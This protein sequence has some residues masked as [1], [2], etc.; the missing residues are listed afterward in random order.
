[1]PSVLPKRHRPGIGDK[2]EARP[3]AE[4]RAAFA[5]VAE[6]IAAADSAIRDAERK[7]RELDRE[8]AR[9]EADRRGKAAEPRLEVR[10]DLA[11]A[12]ATRA[13]LRV[14]Y[15]VRQARWAPLYDARLDT[16]AQ[17]PQARA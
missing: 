16:G 3:I 10:I 1:M 14:T 17:G 9:L 7:Q 11:A 2:G 13:T 15:S 5:A 12:A 6:E 4:W 8:I